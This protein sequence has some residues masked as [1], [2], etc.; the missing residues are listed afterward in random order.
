MKVIGLIPSRL[1]SSRLKNKPLLKLGSIPMV[2]HTYLRAKL[3]RELDE[4][5][6]CCDDKKIAN[7]CKKYNAKYILTSKKHIN[8][9][10]RIGEAYKKIRKKYDLIIDIQGDEPL[11]DPRNIDKVIKCHKKN[12]NSDII[13]PCLVSNKKS[14]KNIV[15]VL[16]NKKEEVMYLSRYNLPFNFKGKNNSYLKHLSIISFKPKS[17]IN[18]CKEK[19]T[20]AEKFEG[21]ELLRAL[22]MGMKIR[23]QILD[24]DSFS[25]DIKEQY[26]RAKKYI[27]KD[28]FYKKY[29]FK[30]EEFL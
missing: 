16:I 19:Q 15:K 2:I 7:E 21:I 27:L 24:G 8:G 17:L 26:I 5:I 29:Q 30:N 20:F 25:V 18:F 22:E 23:T 11:I 12:L 6:I 3:A 1:K 13:L 10:E 14:S 4:V 28:A 9:T